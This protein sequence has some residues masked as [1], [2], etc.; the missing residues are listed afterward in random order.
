MTT[1]VIN[2]AEK[3]SFPLTDPIIVFGLLLLLI[4]S[5]PL[6]LNRI[7]I[8]NIV[9][10]IFSGVLIGP[11][12]LGII[13]HSD[14]ID[15]FSTIGLMYIMFT[16]G[17]E[18]DMNEFRSNKNRSIIFGILTYLLPLGVGYLV[19]QYALQ[20][21][22][23]SSLLIANVFATHTLVSYPIIS[24]LGITKNQAVAVS[25][26]AT[27]I[28]DTLALLAL[29]IIMQGQS[30]SIDPMFFIRMG[31]MLVIF[32]FFLFFVVPLVSKW[33]FRKIES[34]KYTNYVY[35]IFIVFLS[36]FLSEIVGLEPI[37]GAFLVG[38][39][40]NPLLPQTSPLMHRIE[41][42]GNAI[43]I[44][45]FLISVGMLLD[46]KVAVQ[47]TK[48]LI[49]A[50]VLAI[51]ALV[52]KWLAAEISGRLFKYARPQINL[53]FGLST[54]RAAAT[55]AIALIGFKYK[56]I[57]E[58][59]FNAI[60]LLILF[61]CVVSSFITQK[62]AKQIAILEEENP[63]DILNNPTTEK[64]LVPIANP[65]HLV[66]HVELALLM[67]DLRSPNP[68]NLLGVVKNNE[69][70]ENNIL[71]FRKKLKQ[72]VDD[73]TETDLKVEVITT[74]D[75][76]PVNGILRTSREIMSNIV[77]LGWPGKIGRLQRALGDKVSR[78]IN[79][80]EKNLFICHIE[81]KPSTHNR[82][83]VVSPPLAEREEGFKVWLS[84]VIKL[85]QELSAPVVHIGHQSTQKAISKQN[86]ESAKFKFITFNDWSKPLAW[87]NEIKKMDIL[88]LVS[89]HPGYISHESVLDSLP[90]RIEKKFPNTSRI[91]IYPKQQLGQSPLERGGK[92][93]TP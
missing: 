31:I 27:V 70:A 60:I 28:A 5:I 58:N 56:I 57:D 15:M 48:T 8:P 76:N 24:K 87:C 72:V 37:I 78:I 32:S 10:L 38:I 63:N 36:G 52:G 33:M 79:N 80:T 7:N 71:D 25:V 45:I 3:L 26:G 39:A 53:M 67:K 83:V 81:Y 74:I 86:A 29:A 23:I 34:E 17:L 51:V 61:T 11:Y 69:E 9:G 66:H 55:L 85:S 54:S 12:G 41:F 18:L 89:A 75:D 90:T 1:L 16:V 43:F 30:G 91:I 84:K 6:V 47:D 62:A 68:V 65:S 46:L 49:Y 40:L 21:D 42:T 22:F 92:I 35:V 50:S 19:C 44:P 73:A 64:I 14:A 20:Q 82:I 4:F 88:I 77:V 2:I 59:I 93:F 13:E